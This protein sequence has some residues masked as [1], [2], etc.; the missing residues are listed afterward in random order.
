MWKAA[1]AGRPDP[2]AD[3]RYLKAPKSKV[4]AESSTARVTSF[5]QTLYESI[6][7]NLPD[8]KDDTM[9]IASH[10]LPTDTDP[11]ALA[12]PA[13]LESNKKVRQYKKGV[14]IHVERAEM[15]GTEPR[16]LPPGTMMEYFEQFQAQEG[17]PFIS[18]ST[19]WRTW[20]VEFDHLR[21]R[22][23]S[24]HAQCSCCLH[25][26]VLLKELSPYLHARNHQASLYRAHLVSQ[27]RDRLCYWSLRGSSRLKTI[28]HIC[29]MQDGMDQC[30]FSL[31]RSH[32][33]R[34]KDLSTLMKPK[35]AVIGILIHGF[36]LS[37]TIS[38]AEH[39]KDSSCMSEV[40][41]WA[42]TKLEKH[43]RVCLA[44]T[45]IHLFADNTARETKNNTTVRLLCA[46][47]QRRSLLLLDMAFVHDF[48]V[49]GKYVK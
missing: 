44:N 41:G 34:A 46:L 45:V 27:Y 20:R 42:L 40:L 31:P 39:P 14:K 24:S 36:E 1:T 4:T 7:E 12:S 47:C 35:L 16:Y 6:A 23:T 10:G 30:K 43:H 26:R 2:P 38:T 18:F 37:F 49:C 15:S 25:H 19:F 8:V 32:L 28:G 48:H 5:L 11:Y 33:T 29:I 22:S 21:F 9:E 3:L 13:T 17:L